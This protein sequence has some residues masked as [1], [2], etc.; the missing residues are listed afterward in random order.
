MAPPSIA[1][2]TTEATEGNKEPRKVAAYNKVRTDSRTQ[3]LDV[4]MRKPQMQTS[5]VASSSGTSVERY[6]SY[7][8]GGFVTLCLHC[9]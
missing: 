7:Y 2:A 3:T 1:A 6:V 9:R 5:A 8:T 4:F